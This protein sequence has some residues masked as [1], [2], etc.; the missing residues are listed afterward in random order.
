MTENKQA[1]IVVTQL[2]VLNRNEPPANQAMKIL[3][4]RK[5]L[6]ASVRAVPCH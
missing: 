1:E 2:P 4:K 5:N 3:Q 6:G